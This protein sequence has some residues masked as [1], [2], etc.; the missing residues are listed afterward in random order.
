MI[1]LA[2]TASMPSM[3]KMFG[4]P[5]HLVLNVNTSVS[6]SITGGAGVW[7]DVGIRVDLCLRGVGGISRPNPGG[8]EGNSIF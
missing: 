7:L 2:R 6:E 3:S 5:V 4:F 1:D 8:R